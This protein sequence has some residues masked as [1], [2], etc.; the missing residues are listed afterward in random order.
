MVFRVFILLMV[1]SGIAM[2]QELEPRAYTPAPMGTN[3]LGFAFAR[4]TGDIA[5][6][7][8]LPIENVQS[9]I[10]STSVYYG[11]TFGL[12]GRSSSVT[13]IAPYAWGN[14]S[15]DVGE[16]R[17]EVHRSG[18]VDARFRFAMNLLGGPSLTVKEFATRKIVPTVGTSLTVV[19]P[20][21]Q[22]DSAKLVN[23]GS[24][25]WAFKPEVG[26]SYPVRRWTLEAYL[27]VWLFTD[28]EDFFG[29]NLRSQAAIVSLQGH[30]GYTFRPRLWIAGDM[31]FYRGGQTTL[32]DLPKADLQKNSRGG[33]TFS[34]PVKK[35]QS[36]KLSWSKGVTTRIGGNFTTY[37]AAWQF[38]WFGAAALLR[39]LENQ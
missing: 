20:T 11:R 6:D 17:G 21:G 30:V 1:F 10:Q 37:T 23:L 8:S 22:Y 29:G 15:G 4:S 7:P 2:A 38:T 36:I 19:S 26:F 24:N 31:T 32:N 16:Q 28:N 13:A 27:G 18:L 14:V 12:F 34:F 33:V 3:F 35:Y 25:R 39:E 9:E 5:T